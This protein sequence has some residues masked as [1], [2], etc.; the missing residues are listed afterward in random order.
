M[1]GK[2]LE[3]SVQN[4]VLTDWSVC[5]RN[6]LPINLCNVLSAIEPASECLVLQ[7]TKNVPVRFPWLP[8]NEAAPVF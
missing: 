8:K 4:P 7:P 6:G 3:E 5:A 1:F 2:V